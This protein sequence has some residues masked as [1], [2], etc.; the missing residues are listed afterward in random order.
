M[1]IV[2]GHSLDQQTKYVQRKTWLSHLAFT[3]FPRPELA[4]FLVV[5]LSLASESIAQ[6]LQSAVISCKHRTGFF[7]TVS[8][9]REE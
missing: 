4:L 3:S 7:S 1:R 8:S 2:D 5:P 6:T 9:V